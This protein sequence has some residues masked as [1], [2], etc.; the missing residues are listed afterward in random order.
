MLREVSKVFLF[1]A[2]QLFSIPAISKAGL[3]VSSIHGPHAKA[4]VAD[5]SWR[6]CV[7]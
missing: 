2:Q 7:Q 4:T 1:T 5:I 6:D 3:N